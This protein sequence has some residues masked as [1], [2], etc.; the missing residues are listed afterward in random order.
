MLPSAYGLGAWNRTTDLLRVTQVFC[1][2]NYAKMKMVGAVGL[3]P[4]LSRLST[5]CFTI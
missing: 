4:T 3:A 2:L 1:Q 5:E